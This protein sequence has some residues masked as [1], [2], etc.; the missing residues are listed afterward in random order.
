MKTTSSFFRAGTSESSV[1]ATLLRVTVS[2]RRQSDTLFFLRNLVPTR[3]ML[4]CRTIIVLSC[5]LTASPAPAAEDVLQQAIN[6]V[7][8][9]TIEPSK[10]GPELVDRQSCIVVVPEP[11]FNRYARYYLR[12]F[13]MDTSRV[14]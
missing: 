13:K 12:R 2:S 10:D 9:G 4:F 8:T 14:S 11:K 6:Y 5:L 7:F 3:S 1:T